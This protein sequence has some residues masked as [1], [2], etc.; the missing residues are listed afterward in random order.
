MNEKI[1]E[2]VKEFINSIEILWGKLPAEIKV[3]V[4]YAGSEALLEILDGAM[5]LKTVD[6]KV[7]FSLF[8]ANVILVFAKNLKAR[9]V[10]FKELLG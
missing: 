3:G 10:K 5:G 8:V 6:P 7:V 1:L 4:Y 9:V 2:A